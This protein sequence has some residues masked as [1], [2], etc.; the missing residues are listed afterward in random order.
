MLAQLYHRQNQAATLFEICKMHF[1]CHLWGICDLEHCYCIAV[2]NMYFQ[3]KMGW[4]QSPLTGLLFFFPLAVIHDRALLCS[5]L[6]FTVSC[7]VSI[8]MHDVQSACDVSG[9]LYFYRWC[10]PTLWIHTSSV[11]KLLSPVHS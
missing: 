2:L 10:F 6:L 7:I 5:Q 4:P 1:R 9:L 11:C 8:I 3:R